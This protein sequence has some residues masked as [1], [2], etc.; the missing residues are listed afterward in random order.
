MAALAISLV[1]FH[2]SDTLIPRPVRAERVSS[3][4][5]DERETAAEILRPKAEE[6][7]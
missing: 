1:H 3:E 2:S 7:P 5:G 4:A 6:T